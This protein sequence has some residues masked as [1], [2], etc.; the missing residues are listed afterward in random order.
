[1]ANLLL[2]PT[3]KQHQFIIESV[4]TPG[5]VYHKQLS[6]VDVDP[7]M[8]PKFDPNDL[9]VEMQGNMLG[10]A[11]FARSKSSITSGGENIY[12]TYRQTLHDKFLRMY[13]APLE[14]L[15]MSNSDMFTTGDDSLY[16]HSIN[17][18]SPNKKL[19]KYAGG[20]PN[21]KKFTAEDDEMIGLEFGRKRSRKEQNSISG[22]GPLSAQS[23]FDDKGTTQNIREI[24]EQQDK[25][26]HTKYTTRK[27]EYTDDPRRLV[28][29]WIDDR[30]PAEEKA[31]LAQKDYEDLMRNKKDR[32]SGNKQSRLR[33]KS[34][35]SN[36]NR[37][38]SREENI[39]ESKGVKTKN[40]A[41]K[42]KTP[43]K[44]FAELGAVE[45]Q[46]LVP[47]K[48]KSSRSTSKVVKST[49]VTTT[50]IRK[51]RRPQEFVD[52]TS[53]STSRSKSRSRVTPSK[54]VN[55]TRTD[56]MTSGSKSRGKSI[57]KGRASKSKTPT[58]KLITDETNIKVITSTVSSRLQ[59]KK[60]NEYTN[61]LRSRSPKSPLVSPGYSPVDAHFNI[62]M[63]TQLSS[64][65]N[66][67]HKFYEEDEHHKT[68][69][70]VNDKRNELEKSR[71]SKIIDSSTPEAIARLLLEQKVLGAVG[72]F[73]PEIGS[74]EEAEHVSHGLIK[75]ESTFKPLI[76]DKESER[77]KRV[78]EDSLPKSPDTHR[79]A[80][81][82][83][84]KMLGIEGENDLS[85]SPTS[86]ANI[87]EQ[88]NRPAFEEVSGYSIESD[89]EL[90]QDVKELSYDKN[91]L[92]LN[93]DDLKA[94]EQQLHNMDKHK[95][96]ELQLYQ[97]KKRDAAE[98]EAHIDG[99][100]ETN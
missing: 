21:P 84:R 68:I 14:T 29:I 86:E 53:K 58:N 22:G 35:Q 8:Q 83:S 71:Y 12:D 97:K 99:K 56:T 46:V 44:R 62:K 16:S 23:K 85:S 47:K 88:M 24:I 73:F 42:S 55:N 69:K 50:I 36:S 91:D 32:L 40:S 66:G 54:L 76:L 1:M 43:L 79:S 70:L 41:V 39:S 67:K 7:D 87:N 15:P 11:S 80:N 13:M 82:Q 30:V 45:E 34:R 94:Q 72:I 28:P 96:E 92:E 59:S 95:K 61:S 77:E 90:Y 74:D 9:V 57:K 49:V 6:Q 20:S 17:K 19:S 52:H 48:K 10:R 51:G 75:A 18:D 4:A 25:E 64:S 33:S 81:S 38:K 27:A 2:P 60:G 93:D 100:W 78:R 26:R 65:K 63:S 98:E 5:V 37:S 89:G 3:G 31:M